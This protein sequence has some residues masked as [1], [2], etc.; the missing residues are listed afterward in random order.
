ML[1]KTVSLKLLNEKKNARLS[2][3]QVFKFAS[4]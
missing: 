4:G 2:E 3:L 1:T